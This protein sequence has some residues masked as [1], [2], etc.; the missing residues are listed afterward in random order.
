MDARDWRGVGLLVLTMEA[1]EGPEMVEMAFLKLA[2]GL[3]V[4]AIWE[5]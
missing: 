5:G 3:V 2:A 1:R 4:V